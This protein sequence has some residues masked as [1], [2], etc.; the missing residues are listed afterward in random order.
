MNRL[1]ENNGR[2]G[3]AATQSS[4]DTI[5]S[6]NDNNDSVCLHL[7]GTLPCLLSH[8]LLGFSKSPGIPASSD[9]YSSVSHGGGDMTQIRT[10]TVSAARKTKGNTRSGCFS[11]L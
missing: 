2:L 8:G 11:P 9:N 6:G 7:L 4:R 3:N 10:I 1:P 5:I